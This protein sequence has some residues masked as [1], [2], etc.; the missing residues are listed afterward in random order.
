MYPDFYYHNCNRDIKL[1]VINFN[2]L[3]FNCCWI[4]EAFAVFA[5]IR[6]HVNFMRCWVWVKRTLQ[7]KVIGSHPEMS[8]LLV[9]SWTSSHRC[10]GTQFF[11]LFSKRSLCDIF[12]GPTMMLRCEIQK[13]INISRLTVCLHDTS[14]GGTGIRISNQQ[15]AERFNQKSCIT[16]KT[17]RFKL[18]LIQINIPN[19]FF[20]FFFHNISSTKL[21]NYFSRFIHGGIHSTHTHYHQ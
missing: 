4:S 9:P 13:K 15:M 2:G 10:E 18:K 20:F 12:K 14:H 11:T 17:N 5:I 7:G 19:M 21:C 16:S 3:S 1:M 6:L 8:M